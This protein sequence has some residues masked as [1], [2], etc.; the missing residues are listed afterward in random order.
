MSYNGSRR[1]SQEEKVTL[2]FPENFIK[3]DRTKREPEVIFFLGAGASINAGIPDT[4]TFVEKFQSYL[5]ENNLEYSE[6]VE[7]IVKNIEDTNL[8]KDVEVLMEVLE[9]KA[10]LGSENPDPL[11]SLSEEEIADIDK[12]TSQDILDELRMFIRNKAIPDSEN[13]E[14]FSNLLKVVRARPLKIF[15]VNYDTC[16]EQMCEKH[17]LNYSDGFE[18]SWDP[19]NFSEDNDINIYKLHGSAIWYRASES[20]FVKLPLSINPQTQL[21]NLELIGGES[22][23]EVILYPSRKDTFL[24]PMIYLMRKFSE[25]L[26]DRTNRLLVVVGYSFRDQYVRDILWEAFRKNPDLRM[27]FISP[28]AP[29]I[30]EDKLK[31]YKPVGENVPSSAKGKVITLPLKFEDIIGE[32]DS[33]LDI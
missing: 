31:F 21:K 9:R 10:S 16:I 6:K 11:L 26:N 27:I 13:V 24:P 19:T 7:N 18:L 32:L 4:K 14:Y 5:E 30:Y 2:E 17:K 25:T 22:L 28:N 12:D 8:T 33:I 20:G 3:R 29:E 1:I 23:S 15:T